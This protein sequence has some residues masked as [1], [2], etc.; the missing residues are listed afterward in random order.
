MQF[1]CGEAERIRQKNIYKQTQKI[2][3]TIKKEER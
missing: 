1:N 2:D 3:N